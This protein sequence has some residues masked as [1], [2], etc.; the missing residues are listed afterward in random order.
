M[1]KITTVFVLLVLAYNVHAQN[2]GIGT[3][4]PDASAVL[5]INSTNKGLLLPRM[6]TAQRNSIVSPAVGLVIF[7]TDDQCT[8]IFDGSYWIKN[9]GYKQGDS[10]T[11]P[12]NSW[13]QKANFGGT[14]RAGAVGFSIGNK[15]YIGTGSDGSGYKN[16][17][18]EYDPATNLWTQKANFGGTGRSD[19]VGFSIGNKGYIGTGLNGSSSKN[20][21]WEYDPATNIWTQKANFG[22][23]PRFDAVGFSFGNKGYIGTGYNSSYMNDFWEYD[24][25]TNLW[26]QKANFGGEARR[27]AVGFSIGNKAYIGTGSTNFFYKNDFWE[28]DLGTSGSLGTWTQK[29]NFGGPPREYAVGFSF[30]DKGY[31][32]TGY[33]NIRLND[34]WEYNP[35]TNLWI[36]KANFEGGATSGAVGFSY[37]NKGYISTG[38]DGTSL[39]NYLW[40][41]NP[42]AYNVASYT[43]GSNMLSQNNFSDGIWKKN[44]LH[45]VTTFNKVGIGLTNPSASLDVEGGIRTKYSGTQ[46]KSVPGGTSIINLTI[47]SLPF[48]WDFTNTMVTVT[49]V[50]GQSGTIYQTKLTSLTNIQVYFT[51]NSGT[52]S[53]ARFNYI[54]FKL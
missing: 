42:Q 15:V 34:F 16:D 48:D 23:S 26:T 36:Q 3:A 28:Y 1:K 41:Y 46:V 10:A 19:A 53:T 5:D 31:I 30:G 25:A 37:A 7:N 22:G 20:D 14:A 4:T 17:F 11:V 9:C 32:G 8:D 43:A 44:L 49:N 47:P 13:V 27:A 21:F 52:A 6:S 12:A 29:A 33:S 2:V 24:P 40:E 38:Y 50:D 39:N 45:Q 18:W 51:S 54:I 35:S